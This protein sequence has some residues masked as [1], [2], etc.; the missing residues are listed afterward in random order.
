MYCRFCSWKWWIEAIW[1]VLHSKFWYSHIFPLKFK[2][3]NMQSHNLSRCPVSKFRPLILLFSS[4]FGFLSFM[5]TIA[6]LYKCYTWKNYSS[7]EQHHMV[8]HTVCFVYP[9]HSTLIKYLLLCSYICFNGL[10]EDYF[11]RSKFDHFRNI[12]SCFG[13]V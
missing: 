9:L 13:P 4:K 3:Y 8:W 12:V 7:V 5:H 2:H 6:R 11:Y 10:V 1:R